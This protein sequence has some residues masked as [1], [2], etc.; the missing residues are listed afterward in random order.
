M[1]E[2]VKI[3]TDVPEKKQE[4]VAS[5]ISQEAPSDDADLIE[6]SVSKAQSHG[7]GPVWR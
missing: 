2:P 5:P 1:C 7:V 3:K 4:N 6:L